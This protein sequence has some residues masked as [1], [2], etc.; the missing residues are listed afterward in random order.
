MRQRA[1]CRRLCRYF[2]CRQPNLAFLPSKRRHHSHDF[3]HPFEQPRAAAL[4][5]V[6]LLRSNDIQALAVLETRLTGAGDAAKPAPK[7]PRRKR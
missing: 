4:V 1:K 5:A 6:A 3:T 2:P 7:A